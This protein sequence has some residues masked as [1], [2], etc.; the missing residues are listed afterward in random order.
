MSRI[1]VILAVLFVAAVGLYMY[2]QKYPQAVSIPFGPDG[3]D[4][5]QL[6]AKMPLSPVDLD[7]LTP[8]SLKALTQEQVDQLY[9]RLTAGP[10]PD[11]PFD[12]DLFFPRGTDRSRFAEVVGGGIAGGLKGDAADIQVAKLEFLGEKLWKGKVFDRKDRLLRNR[13]TD[14][15]SLDVLLTQEEEAQL[16]SLRD[17]TLGQYLLFPARLYCGE[18]LLDGRR[19]SIIIDYAYTDQLPGYLAK[20][21]RLVGR[22]GLAI[23]DEIRM[24]RPG[25]YLGR[26]YLNRVFGVNFT[27]Y[28]AK[29]A[30]AGQADFHATGRVAEDCWTGEQKR[31]AQA[32]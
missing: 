13:I 25:F 8:Q 11:A 4:F 17:P 5:A 26:A 21:D 14:L 20:L 22:E 28:N 6:E 29:V 12:G 2:V 24:V 18:S 7:K 30:E 15:K 23:R 3:I 27:L 32:T 31:H 10:I 1:L 9:A 16:A 19:E